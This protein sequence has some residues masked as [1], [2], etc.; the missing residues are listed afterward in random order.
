VYH[1]FESSLLSESGGTYTF[2][3]NVSWQVGRLH[4]CEVPRVMLVAT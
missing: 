1:R 3:V 4:G 2:S